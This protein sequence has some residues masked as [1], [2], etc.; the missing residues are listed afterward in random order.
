MSA[1]EFV[2]IGAVVGVNNFAVA[3]MLGSLGQYGRRWRVVGVFG[4]F[5]FTVPLIGLALGAAVAGYLAGVGSLIG[6]FL[7]LL[8]GAFAVHAPA[9]SE[10]E[11]QRLAR[12]VTTWR[13]LIALA[14][15]LTM[16][17]LIVGFALGLGDTE[18]LL[19]AAT[20]AAF[21]LAF[22][23]IGLELGRHGRRERESAAQ[24]ASGVLLI[25]LGVGIALGW[26][27]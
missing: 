9:R 25:A 12:Q 19:L 15:G 13:G 26:P 2:S 14:A 24:T 23:L 10:E 27:G 11:R 16:D 21:A 17:N 6:A 3:L 8:L 5:E 1:A 4:L 20:I 18:P 7:L 22:T